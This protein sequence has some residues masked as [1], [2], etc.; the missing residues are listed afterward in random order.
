MDMF[1]Y[2]SVLFAFENWFFSN[3][4]NSGLHG[5]EL[6]VDFVFGHGL[7]TILQTFIETL[8]RRRHAQG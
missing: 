5:F 7:L 1:L 2:Y 3:G 4:D 6:K 8:F